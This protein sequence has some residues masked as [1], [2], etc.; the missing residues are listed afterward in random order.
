MLIK[1]YYSVNSMVKTEG[2]AEFSVSLNP[3]CGVYKGHFPSR[4]ICPGVCNINMLTECAEVVA[5]KR[6]GIKEIRRCR[7]SSLVVPGKKLRVV[8]ILS[9]GQASESEAEAQSVYSLKGEIFEG[10]TSC[11]SLDCS[12][13]ER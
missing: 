10:E 12:L 2:G 6:F 11:M 4:P 1:D 13:E 3:D 8:V 7:L 5:G 9:E